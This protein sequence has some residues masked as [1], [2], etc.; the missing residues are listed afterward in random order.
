M[1][2]VG[3]AQFIV[4]GC[5]MRTL[6]EVKGQYPYDSDTIQKFLMKYHYIDPKFIGEPSD[7]AGLSP[8]NDTMFLTGYLLQ[9]NLENN[10]QFKQFVAHIMV[11][12]IGIAR[13]L[14][15]TTMGKEPDL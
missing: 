8:T 2:L 14:A 1:E 3:L 7:L 12:Q 11:I 9:R 15:N 13:K 10:V 5:A 6:I 4:Y